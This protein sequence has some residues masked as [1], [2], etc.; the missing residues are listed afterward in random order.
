MTVESHTV[1]EHSQATV[2]SE[3]GERND[4]GAPNREEIFDILSNERR[5][6]TLYYLTEQGEETVPLRDVVD[7]VAAWENDRPI[8]DVSSS[9]R[10]CT[11]SALHQSHLPKLARTG[12]IDYDSQRGEI[13]LR[14]AARDATMY[15]EYDPG[16]D[17]SWSTYYLGL[18]ALS[19]TLVGLVALDVYP[20]DGLST[21]L[22]AGL[23]VGMLGVSALFQTYY[24]RANRFDVGELFDVDETA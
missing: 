13:T 19:G 7:H 10:M 4:V 18:T 11:Y 24:D 1:S 5:R 9:E 15:L 6:C 2:E 20:F 12:L 14:E 23:V 3:L 22:V 16:N 17:I 21:A 8:G